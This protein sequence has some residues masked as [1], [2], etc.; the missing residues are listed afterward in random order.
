MKRLLSILGFGLVFNAMGVIDA[1]E[2]PILTPH[3]ATRKAEFF[4]LADVRLLNG[5]LQR[6]QELNRQYLLRL[7]P[8]RLLSWFRREAGLEPKAPPYRGWE[9]E[10]RALPGH[11]LGFYMSG[12]AMTVQATGDEILRQRLNYIVTQLAEVQVANRSGYMLAVK[13]GK[14]VFAEIAAGRIEIDGLP[15]N[16]Y[17]INGHFEP[18]YTMNKLMLGLVTIYEATGNEQAKQVFLKLAD[19]FGAEIINKLDDRQVQTLMQCEHGSLHESYADAYRLSGNGNYLAWARRICHERMLT[20]LAGNDR[21]FITHF[22]AN[23]NIPKYT[24]FESI[25]QLTGESRLHAAAVNFWDEVVE[26][27]SWVIG[28]NSANEHFFDPTEFTSVLNAPAG[29]E[30]CN[31]VN[32]LRLTEALFQV[33]PTPKR[34][35]YYE[36]ALFNHILASHDPERA[37]TS[38]YTTMRPGGYRVYSDEFDSMWCCTGTGLEVPGKYARMIFTHAPDNTALDVNLFVS[39]QLEWK[40]HQ[41]SVRQTTGF[42]DEPATALTF[43]CQL[44]ETRFKLR[45]RHPAWVAEGQLKITVNGKPVPITSRPES[46]AEIDRSWRSGDVVR[47]ELPMRLSAETLPGDDHYVALLYGPIVLSGALGRGGLTKEDFWQIRTTIPTKWQ[48]E[49]ATPVFVASNTAE[50]V[51]QIR[52]VSGKPL[53]FDTG[54]LVAEKKVNLIPFYENHFQRYAIYWKRCSPSEWLVLQ[55]ENAAAEQAVADL[56]K[57]TV[58]RVLIGN[59]A[60]EK[61]HAFAG[62]KTLSGSGAYEHESALQWRDARDGGWFSYKLKLAEQVEPQALRCTYWGR[63][64]G[65]RTFDVLANGQLLET[66]SLKDTGKDDFI[67]ADILLPEA[68]VRTNSHVT[69]RFQ[70]HAGNSAGGIFDLRVVTRSPASL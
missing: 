3:P 8:D 15:W 14:E 54:D 1:A 9:S 52:P 39:A 6:Q 27:R 29:P 42:P 21:D 60:S 57:R 5:P 26:R 18:T 25:Y 62:E 17:Q 4:P 36:R 47:I 19:W 43:Q 35:D 55:K 11:I 41:V 61:A 45:L 48:V 58:D 65:N 59:D 66:R 67:H 33:E 37:M 46:Y 38:Y 56:E 22:H 2:A 40:E 69:V 32:M 23:S 49:S 20:P 28:G 44:P 64:R 10:G 30:S 34:V 12:A 16:G 13:N 50:V 70:S 53:C 68:L 51:N 63:E 24:G 7:D 31:S